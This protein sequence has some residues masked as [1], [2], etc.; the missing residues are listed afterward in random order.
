MPFFLMIFRFLCA[1]CF[2]YCP[3]ASRSHHYNV[4]SFASEIDDNLCLSATT[5]L[6]SGWNYN[7][8]LATPSKNEN[9]KNMKVEFY[10][11][12]VNNASLAENDI[13]VLADAYDVVFQRD[14]HHFMH[15]L[16]TLLA[17]ELETTKRDVVYFMAEKNCWPALNPKRKEY[18]CPMAQGHAFYQNKPNHTAINCRKQVDLAPSH[19]SHTDIGKF[20]N[21]GLCVGSVRALRRLFSDYEN[22]RDSLVPKC[23]DD[24]GDS[25]LLTPSVETI[26]LSHLMTHQKLQY[27]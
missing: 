18:Y 8:L 26:H 24:Q 17:T 25:H 19:H 6:L 15:K 2:A 5:A 1:I 7:L 11:N 22:L 27:W 13:L 14:V 21:S 12:Y 3:I 23:H 9:A 16:R 4:V 10:K 20:L